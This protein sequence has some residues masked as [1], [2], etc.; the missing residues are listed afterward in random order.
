LGALVP[1]FHQVART[2]AFHR[3]R[4][5]RRCDQRAGDETDRHGR[6]DQI[7]DPVGGAIGGGQIGAADQIGF[8][9]I[10]AA[11]IGVPGPDDQISEAVMVD[12]P[13]GGD[14]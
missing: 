2:Q 5:R 1:G 13:G 12:I 11:A 6:I 7:D 3:H 4:A 10:R 14:V 9:R 8:A